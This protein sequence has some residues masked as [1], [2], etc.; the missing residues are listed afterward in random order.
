MFQVLTILL[1]NI[2]CQSLLSTPDTPTCFRI[3]RILLILVTLLQQT[4]LLSPIHPSLCGQSELLKM[5]GLFFPP[6][7]NPS[8]VLHHLQH[9]MITSLLLKV[10]QGLASATLSSLMFQHFSLV[11][12]HSRNIGLFV[13]SEI[14]LCNFA[15]SLVFILAFIKLRNVFTDVMT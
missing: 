9:K 6:F 8:D 4:S 12:L 14:Y 7:W 2:S 13:I 1:A 11:I 15:L 3:P 10:L 5:L